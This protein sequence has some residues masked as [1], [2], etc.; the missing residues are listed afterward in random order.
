MIVT[1]PCFSVNHFFGREMQE[2][3]AEKRVIKIKPRKIIFFAV[4]FWI[5][6]IALTWYL[7]QEH[8]E[9]LYTLINPRMASSEY[10]TVEKRNAVLFATLTPLKDELFKAVGDNKDNTAFY[11]EDL[12]SGSWIGWK[13]K[14]PFVAASLMKVPVAIGIMK[15]IDSGEWTLDTTFSINAEFKD[16]RFGDLW[17][18]SDGTQMSIKDLL[19]E[20]LQKSDN[21]AMRTLVDKLSDED[22][23]N[24]YYHVGIVNPDTNITEFGGQDVVKLSAKEDAAMFRALYNATYLT[25]KSSQYILDTLTQTDFDQTL[26]KDLA[27]GVE[28]AHKIGNFYNPDPNRPKQYHDCGIAYLTNHPYLFCLMTQNLDAGPAEE[29]I[30]KMNGVIYDYFS[31]SGKK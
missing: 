1:T 19:D 30:T 27:I 10:N 3:K 31:K 14:D 18:V 28:I 13:E 2:R 26:P 22:R 4:L 17:K 15:K 6:S 23:D 11:V 16:D 24:V 29:V 20:M 9:T 5:A 12:N 8:G 25:R 7:S 21:T